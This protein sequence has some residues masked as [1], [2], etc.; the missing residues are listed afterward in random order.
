[1]YRLAILG[2]DSTHTRVF[3]TAF[4]RPDPHPERRVDGARVVKLWGEDAAQREELARELDA[5]PCATPEAACTAVDA[6]LVLN[7][8]GADHPRGARLAIERGLPTFVDKPLTDDLDAARAL[9]ALARARQVP[10][11]SCSSLRFALEV[12]AL[13]HRLEALGDLRAA[14]V[15]GPAPGERMTFYLIHSLEMLF[16]VMDGPVESVFAT[17]QPT[18]D[19][20][21][22]RWPDGR[23]ATVHGLREAPS[24]YHL[25]V[26]GSQ[27]SD[28]ARVTA[29]RSYYVNLLRQ[30]VNWLGTGESPVAPER[31]L[32]II[33]TLNAAEIA[34]RE[35]RPVLVEEIAR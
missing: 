22:L 15:A 32:E 14:S 13:G 19:S 5:E 1:M 2:V 7:R 8:H 21:L 30:I 24:S 20:L 16:A 34:A 35:S 23:T 33:A 11:F 18:H 25:V 12:M 28:A 31:T 27:G 3:G 17:R 29:G 10:L 4:N 9:V 26:Y 6:V